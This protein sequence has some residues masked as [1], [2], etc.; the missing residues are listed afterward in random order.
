M[1]NHT[2]TLFRIVGIFFSL[3]IFWFMISLVIVLL[4]SLF[5]GSFLDITNILYVLGAMFLI[6]I[7]YPKFIFRG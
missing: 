2:G 4:L 5:D 1:S 6:G 3:L 7:F